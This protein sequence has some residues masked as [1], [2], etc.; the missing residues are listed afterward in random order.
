MIDYII[1]RHHRIELKICPFSH[2]AAVSMLSS[3]SGNLSL[4]TTG[5]SLAPP[6][7]AEPSFVGPSPNPL[8]VLWAV[9]LFASIDWVSSVRF[10]LFSR[11]RHFCT[12]RI[13]PLHPR[14]CH[15]FQSLSR[16]FWAPMWLRSCFACVRQLR[17]Q[18]MIELVEPVE[19]AKE[20]A[21]WNWHQ[22]HLI[23]SVPDRQQQENP[24]NLGTAESWEAQKRGRCDMPPFRSRFLYTC[25]VQNRIIVRPSHTIAIKRVMTWSRKHTY[26]KMMSR[27]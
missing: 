21:K 26:A 8:A 7:A 25:H 19:R 15:Q 24:W 22:N 14:C 27:K 23:E 13:S 2:L 3:P 4:G 1:Y 17:H 18:C 5:F 9:A 12:H 10:P 20:R 16:A 11:S 6:P